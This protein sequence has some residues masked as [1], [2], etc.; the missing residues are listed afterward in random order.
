MRCIHA[1]SN[2]VVDF[3]LRTSMVTS[4]LSKHLNR[5]CEAMVTG[6]IYVVGGAAQRTPCAPDNVSCV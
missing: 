6:I 3:Q 4:T 2:A 1:Y 5:I